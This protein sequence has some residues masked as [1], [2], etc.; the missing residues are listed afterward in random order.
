MWKSWG[1][2][3]VRLFGEHDYPVDQAAFLTPDQGRAFHFNS[4]GQRMR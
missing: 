3:T 1:L 4:D 2:L